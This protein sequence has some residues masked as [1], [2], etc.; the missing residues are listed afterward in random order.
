MSKV[1]MIRYI[2]DKIINAET[3]KEKQEILERYKSDTLFKR[4]L[5]YTYNP[6]IVFG[7]D[8]YNPTL[9]EKGVE[10]GMGISKFMHIPEDVYQN[11][12]DEDEARF[13]CNLVF[14]HIN[15]DEAEL[16]LSMLKK[17]NL[18]NLEIS[19]IN[20]VWPELIPEYPVQYPNEYSEENKE[21]IKFP[22]V[23]QPYLNGKRVNI[24]VRNNIVEFNDSDGKQ[25]SGLER[26]GSE[27]STLAQN[28]NTMFDGIYIE[29]DEI[30]FTIWDVIRYDGFVK[31]SDNRLG[32][33]WRFNGF[34][35]MMMLAHE[36]N[37]APCYKGAMSKLVN[38]WIEVEQAQ[39]ELPVTFIIK[40]LDSIWKNGTNELT[41]I[42]PFNN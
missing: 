37:P 24:V 35:H 19:T 30:P 18:L 32:Y 39:K 29:G 40:S 14:S 3:Q 4:V 26:Y 28:N 41:M 31:G 36:H 22:A 33:N 23:I 1:T 20:A 7:M 38:S 25:I 2:A 8:N 6:M 11:R 42:V 9:R 5:Y 12:L 16:F 15:R 10:D 34:E 21:I 17:E 27:F 13:A